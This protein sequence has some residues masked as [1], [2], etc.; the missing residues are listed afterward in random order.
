[1]PF[2]CYNRCNSRLSFL[3]VSKQWFLPAVRGDIPP[4]CAAHGLVCEDTRV[5]VFGGMVEYGKYSNNLYELQVKLSS[6]VE[7]V[8]FRNT[9]ANVYL[10][11]QASRWLW[12]KLKPRAPR[13]GLPPCPRI[14]H[15]FTL[16]GS[17]CYVF[18]GL[19]NVSEDPNGNIPRYV[20]GRIQGCFVFFS[21]IFT[22]RERKTPKTRSKNNSRSI[23]E[24]LKINST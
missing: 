13:N 5:L 11:V 7:A 18:G 2:K 10:M 3:L 17:R 22:S 21:P 8:V 1:M 19:A 15:S 23:E 12:K 4:G 6:R 14:G 9:F 24:K 20:E 16:V